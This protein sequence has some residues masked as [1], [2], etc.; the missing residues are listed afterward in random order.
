[1]KLWNKIIDAYGFCWFCMGKLRCLYG[2]QHSWVDRYAYIARA[3]S[4]SWRVVTLKNRSFLSK[5][6][7][8]FCHCNAASSVSTGVMNCGIFRSVC[9]L[10]L[11]AAVDGGSGGAMIRRQYNVHWFN[12][13]IRRVIQFILQSLYLLLFALVQFPVMHPVSQYNVYIKILL[14]SNFIWNATEHYKS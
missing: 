12:D 3:S 1:M 9:L 7:R 6:R 2:N 13:Q 14:I 11:A 8:H 10:S 4:L 5:F